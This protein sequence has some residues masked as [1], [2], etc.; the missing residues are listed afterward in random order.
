MNNYMR[1]FIDA[2]K[3]MS[4]E[5]IA[6]YGT[7]AV[8]LV[9]VVFQKLVMNPYIIIMI[10]ALYFAIV[11][12][13]VAHGAA[14]NF[15]GDPTAK[16]A[17]RLN[18]NPIKHIDILGL[19]V[20]V[21]MILM[22]SPVVMGWAKPVPVNF[23]L[24]R[25]KKWGTFFV[26]IAG[27]TTNMIIAI[28]AATILKMFFD[29]TVITA[30]FDTVFRSGRNLKELY[31]YSLLDLSYIGALFFISLIVINVGL[32]LF[33]MLPIPPLDGSRVI[34]AFAGPKVKKILRDLEKFGFIILIVL[35]W[36]GV[37]NIVLGPIFSTI[38]NFI[39][40]VYIS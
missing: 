7:I 24:L 34:E 12:H 20:P 8:I 32:A 29:K 17:G 22:G 38:I 23:H 6:I 9:F 33:N 36:T 16:L 40:S 4:K 14:A 30:A 18:F 26:A 3:N 35:L 25:N 28:L 21:F 39:F 11:P 5:T 2:N 10:F 37:I 31:G 27:V 13:E 19:L 15:S 1:R